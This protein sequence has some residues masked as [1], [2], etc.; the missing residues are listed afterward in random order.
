MNVHIT[1]TPKACYARGNAQD[2]VVHIFIREKNGNKMVF[3]N[4]I[5]C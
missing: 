4:F 5:K 3:L 2:S 1:M